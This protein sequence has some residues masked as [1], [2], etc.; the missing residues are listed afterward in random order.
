MATGGVEGTPVAGG[1][2]KDHA[3]EDSEDD[4]PIGQ[5]FAKPEEEEEQGGGEMKVEEKVEEVEEVGKGGRGGRSSR[6]GKQAPAKAAPPTGRTASGRKTKPKVFDGDGDADM[7]EKVV[8]KGKA[9]PKAKAGGGARSR[10]KKAEPEPVEP[11]EDKVE[12]MVEEEGEEAA[13]PISSEEWIQLENVTGEF[14]D[15]QAV[16]VIS[17]SG[18]TCPSGVE[19][20]VSSTKFLKARCIIQ[21]KSTGSPEDLDTFANKVT[22]VG[23]KFSAASGAAVVHSLEAEW[24]RVGQSWSQPNEHLGK[25]VLWKVEVDGKKD[26]ARHPGMVVGWLPAEES[27]Y[28]PDGDDKAPQPL[29]R[30]KMDDLTIAQSDADQFELADALRARETYDTKEKQ[31]EAESR[32]RADKNASHLQVTATTGKRARGSDAKRAANDD[33]VY[34]AEIEAASDSDEDEQLSKRDAR[35]KEQKRSD[36]KWDEDDTGADAW[37]PAVDG[38]VVAGAAAG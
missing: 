4:L 2:R 18:E 5:R 32:R 33:F 11:Q 14:K 35:R 37:K 12:P 17:P 24:H 29:W 6:S 36:Q 19:V 23:A 34:G 16:S 1:E 3:E 30:I 27:D 21:I 10:G 9:K 15:G 25:A 7:E 8:A 13:E 31:R 22:V 38:E 26:H 20:V 28:L